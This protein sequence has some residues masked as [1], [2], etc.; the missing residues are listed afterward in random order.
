MGKKSDP[1][2]AVLI[3]HLNENLNLVKLQRNFSPLL[4]QGLCLFGSLV[5]CC[6][7]K[8]SDKN[9]N[10]MN[11]SSLSHLCQYPDRDFEGTSA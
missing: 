7:F 4:F 5:F 11:N 6:F 3:L 8:L 2:H 9:H 1:N 10:M